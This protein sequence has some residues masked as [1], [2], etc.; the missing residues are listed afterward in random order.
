MAGVPTLRTN[1]ATAAGVVD[2]KIEAPSRRH[3]RR[4]EQTLLGQLGREPD[5]QALMVD[6]AID[7]AF[8]LVPP[9]SEVTV[10]LD[11]I[12]RHMGAGHA[13][14]G[15]ASSPDATR[16]DMRVRLEEQ[17]LTTVTRSEVTATVVAATAVEAERLAIQLADYVAAHGPE[18]AEQGH[19]D[20][21]DRAWHI[22]IH[23]PRSATVVHG[24]S[25]FFRLTSGDPDLLDS[26]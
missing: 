11:Q 16:A 19:N 3:L 23:T 4:T 9:P 26:H 13:T 22:T 17:A 25:L 1:H 21:V 6:T 18:A 10:S 7:R 2:L 14:V 8:Q 15:I 20:W 12:A 5:Q 24:S